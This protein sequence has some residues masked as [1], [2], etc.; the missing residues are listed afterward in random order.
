MYDNS[1]QQGGPGQESVGHMVARVVGVGLLAVL[2]LGAAVMLFLGIWIGVGTVHGKYARGQ[3]VKNAQ[4]A[5]TVERRQIQ[6]ADIQALAETENVKVGD[7]EGAAAVGGGEGDQ[8]G[9]GRDQQHA[10]RAVHPARGDPGAGGH[11]EQRPEQHGDL[12][13]GRDERCADGGQRPGGDRRPERQHAGLTA[14][15][16]DDLSRQ[17]GDGTFVEVMPLTFGRA[18]LVVTDPS[19]LWVY[20]GW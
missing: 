2:G 14:M 15:P 3:R 11:R 10:Y 7:G 17:L 1:G 9:A 6:L 8:G 12:R 16:V 4:N 18:R 5:V 19:R 20:G 13:A